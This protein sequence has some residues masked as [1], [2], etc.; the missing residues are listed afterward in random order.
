M[1]TSRSNILR[2]VRLTVSQGG[3]KL[4][5]INPVLEYGMNSSSNKCKDPAYYYWARLYLTIAVCCLLSAQIY[6]FSG[7]DLSWAGLIFS[8]IHLS[9]LS[10]C[11]GMSDIV[12]SDG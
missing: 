10:F 5:E 4:N 9:A 11:P 1:T 6:A 12:V 7:R 3:T 8:I 2:L